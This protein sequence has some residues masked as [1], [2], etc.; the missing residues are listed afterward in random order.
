MIVYGDKLPDIMQSLKRHTAKNILEQLECDNKTWL[1]N[2]FQ[3]YKLSHKS[4]SEHQV[5]Q[6]GY[7]PQI[8]NSDNI[9]KQ[10]VDYIHMNPVR[11]GFV[12]EPEDWRFSS[13]RYYLKKMECDVKI[14]ELGE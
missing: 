4:G 10:K 2:Q 11:K 14:D 9:L 7:H 12:C 8:I 1:L 6:E 13:A 3:F 5:W